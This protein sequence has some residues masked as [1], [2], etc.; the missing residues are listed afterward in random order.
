[1]IFFLF[2]FMC[3]ICI[4]FFYRACVL[5]N[6]IVNITI[7]FSP[8]ARCARTSTTSRSLRMN[9]NDV[10]NSHFFNIFCNFHNYFQVV[11]GTSRCPSDI[12]VVL[13]QWFAS[14]TF[15]MYQDGSPTASRSR[16]I[17]VWKFTKFRKI[18]EKIQ[19][20][21]NSKWSKNKFGIENV[22]NMACPSP[23]VTGKRFGAF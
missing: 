10:K 22:E 18:I 6:N 7:R 3:L 19:F 9:I 4:H 2:F 23:R 11:F 15:Y 13:F 20:S 17:R 21:V 5:N 14:W 16:D 1:M 8:S 12:V